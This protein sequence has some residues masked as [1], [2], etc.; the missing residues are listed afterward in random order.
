MLHAK[1]FLHALPARHAQCQ[2]TVEARDCEK[3]N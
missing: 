1:T 3:G 2:E